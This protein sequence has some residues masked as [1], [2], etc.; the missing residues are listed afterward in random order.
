MTRVLLVCPEPLGHGQ[1]AGVGIRF[2]EIARALL[3]EGHEV[4][5]LSPDG[6]TVPG[7]RG[8][9]L[10][11]EALR[12]S[13][14]RSECIVAQGHI[15]N[16]ILSHGAPRPLAIDLYDPWIVENFHYWHSHGE[17]V[18]RH[19]HATLM[20]SLRKGD[21]FLCASEAQ[22]LFY[23]GLLV[24]I[25]RLHPGVFD[26]D[27][28]LSSLLA[29][30]PFGVQPPR[31]R[32]DVPRSRDLFFGAIYD[33]YDPRLAIDAVALARTEDSTL[34]L[35]FTGHPNAEGT[36]QSVFEETREWV[37]R[38]GHDFVRF[39]PWVPYEERGAFYDRFALALLTFR[40]SLETDLAMRTRMFDCFWGGL[41]VVSS[42]AGGTDR[43]VRE[44]GAGR[45][46]RSDRP[47]EYAEAI[48][49][50]LEPGELSRAADGCRR[51]TEAHQ[52]KRVLSPLLEFCRRP[53]IDDSKDLFTL[54]E[55]RLSDDPEPL[56]RRIQRRLR[57]LF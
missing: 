48:L 1:P 30:A 5:V 2:L 44:Y 3:S 22:R 35:T 37:R 43:L 6:G 25:G 10:S 8:T 34:T 38:E 19:D 41:P 39:T 7:A 23:A 29:I 49:E 40:P 50:L 31:P 56:F 13:T 4:D 20:A 15:V 32:R 28:E 36:P 18:F 42:R 47:A 52:W 21:F 53:R 46:V 54:D 45:I 27:P 17:Q 57:R 51:F 24:S 9:T 26:R 55:Q 12:I 33:W 14:D 16:E 11:P